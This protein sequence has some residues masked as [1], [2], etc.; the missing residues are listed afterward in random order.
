LGGKLWQRKPGWTVALSQN[1]QQVTSA[2]IG[3]L[4]GSSLPIHPFICSLIQLIFSRHPVGAGFGVSCWT[5]EG[6]QPQHKQLHLW[7][8]FWKAKPSKNWEPLAHCWL[9][10]RAELGRFPTCRDYCF[11]HKWNHVDLTEGQSQKA[12]K[13]KFCVPVLWMQWVT[14]QLPALSFDSPRSCIFVFLSSILPEHAQ[15]LLKPSPVGEKLKV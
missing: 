4:R 6:N 8:V 9:Q 1:L 5:Y 15:I 10:P 2:S 12:K 7:W 13:M 3:L 14:T 11:W